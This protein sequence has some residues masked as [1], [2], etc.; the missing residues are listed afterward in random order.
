MYY[1]TYLITQKNKKG[2]KIRIFLSDIKNFS[3]CQHT[4]S[5]TLKILNIFYA[6]FFT[7][8]YKS[9]HRILHI[10]I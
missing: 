1:G 10:F 2:R 4:H 3:K 8:I 6:I 5:I 7:D 9:V